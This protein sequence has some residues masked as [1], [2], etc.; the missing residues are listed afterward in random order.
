MASAFEYSSERT[1]TGLAVPVPA[2]N[3]ATTTL[4]YNRWLHEVALQQTNRRLQSVIPVSHSSQARD[5]EKEEEEEREW[6][7]SGR[8]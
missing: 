6:R 8:R 2:E 5:V 1:R 3:T 4:W 7:A